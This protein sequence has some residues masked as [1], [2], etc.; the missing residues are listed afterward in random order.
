MPRSIGSSDESRAKQPLVDRR[1]YLAAARS[2][3]YAEPGTLDDIE[4]PVTHKVHSFNFAS[5]TSES[6]GSFPQPEVLR[7]QIASAVL[8]HSEVAK[9]ALGFYAPPKEIREVRIAAAV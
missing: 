8:A 7:R 2:A 5:L 1:L 4:T 6:W 3:R 9:E